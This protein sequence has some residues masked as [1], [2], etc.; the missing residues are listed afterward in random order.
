MAEAHFVT[1]GEIYEC[2]KLTS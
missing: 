2:L 1:F